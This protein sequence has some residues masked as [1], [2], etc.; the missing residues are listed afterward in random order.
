MMRP[1][2]PCRSR[3]GGRRRPSRVRHR[4]AVLPRRPVRRRSGS[5]KGPSVDAADRER[6][7]RLVDLAVRARARGEKIGHCAGCGCLWSERT[8]TCPTCQTR[9]WNR[10]HRSANGHLGLVPR[11]KGC[12]VPWP[13]RTVGCRACYRREFRDRH[14]AGEFARLVPDLPQVVAHRVQEQ[15]DHG[16]RRNPPD[17]PRELPIHP[18]SH[19]SPADA[20]TGRPIV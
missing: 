20:L 6:L 1:G 9:H 17:K 12:G 19:G 7:R 10:R 13:E 11:C 16:Q 4:C 3:P 15:P 14:K 5:K 8:P 18:A 2:G